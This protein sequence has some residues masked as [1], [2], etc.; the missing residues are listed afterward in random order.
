MLKIE[1]EDLKRGSVHAEMEDADISSEKE[2]ICRVFVIFL[3]TL[4]VHVLGKWAA[5][6][7]IVIITTGC[8]QAISK[9]DMKRDV[10]TYFV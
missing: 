9:K 10:I 4:K 3:M 2:D 6:H 5:I 7:S 1:Q 8:M